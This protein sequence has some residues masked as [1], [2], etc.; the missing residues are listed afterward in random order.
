MDSI[1][2]RIRYYRNKRGLTQMEVAAALG[3]RTDNYSKYESGSRTPKDDRLIA[4]AKI[5]GTSYNAL[6]EGVEREFADLL[7]SHA[8]RAVTGEAGSVTAFASDFQMSGDA[9]YIVS[10]FFL[11]GEHDFVAGNVPFYQK[12]LADPDLASLIELY[13]IY[14]DLCDTHTPSQYNGIP[15]EVDYLTSSLDAVTTVKWGFCIAMNRYLMRNDMDTIIDEAEMLAGGV[16]ESFDALQF[17]SFR[18]FVPYLSLVIDAV[19]LCMNTNID[20]FAKA[21]LFYA[22]TP[23]DDWDDDSGDDEE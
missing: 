13:D 7:K 5:L 22:L 20:D 1:A 17:F 6:R 2:Y 4:L 10:N 3:I 8:I 21:F 9:Y 14:R 11:R 23:P 15:L 18:V 16:L 19:E 12:Y